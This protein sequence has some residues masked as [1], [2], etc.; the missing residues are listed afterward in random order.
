MGAQEVAVRT[1]TEAAMNNEQSM[2][3]LKICRRL[4]A[5]LE[6]ALPLDRGDRT[7]PRLSCS[8]IPFVAMFKLLRLRIVQQPMT[9]SGRAMGCCSPTDVGRLT[10]HGY[11]RDTQLSAAS[12]GEAAGAR[13]AALSTVVV[14]QQVTRATDRGAKRHNRRPGADRGSR[15]YDRP[16]LRRPAAG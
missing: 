10:V 13:H 7:T 3:A 5:V 8:G 14:Y 15:R 11:D 2:M 1:K 12:G 9:S 4:I 16:L 6:I